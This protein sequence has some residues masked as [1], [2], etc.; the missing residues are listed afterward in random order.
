MGEGQRRGKENQKD[1]II[2]LTHRPK[3]AQHARAT[4]RTSKQQDA[5]MQSNNRKL[6]K[7]INSE[8]THYNKEN[9]TQSNTTP[10]GTT[11]PTQSRNRI[12]SYKTRECIA[13]TLFTVDIAG[14][15]G[16]SEE[17]KKGKGKGI[18][19]FPLWVLQIV[20]SNEKM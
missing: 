16:K 10:K 20:W 5:T 14:M 3:L 4:Q 11:P 12:I 18:L 2:N 7:D 19:E 8:R 1:F 17:G 13:R 6:K 15:N 9:L